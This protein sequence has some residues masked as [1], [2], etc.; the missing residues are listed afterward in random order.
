VQEHEK[1][2]QLIEQLELPELCLKERLDIA[3]QLKELLELEYEHPRPQSIMMLKMCYR[4]TT[5]YE[6]PVFAMI[7]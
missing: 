3:C 6:P 5:Y 4:Q 7:R 1:L 2:I